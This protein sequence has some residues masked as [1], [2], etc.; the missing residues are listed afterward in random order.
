[1]NVKEMPAGCEMDALITEKV[2]G[3]VPCDAWSTLRHFPPMFI[4]GACEH[5]TCYP[6]GYPCKYSSNM[7][8]AWQ[9]IEKLIELG[10]E[11]SVCHLSDKWVCV[12]EGSS[13]GWE[14]D[15]PFD[16]AAYSE[17]APLAICRAALLEIG[18]EEIEA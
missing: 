3:A 7:G 9:V 4:R 2:M 16:E 15:L 13:A 1:M 17:T 6:R 12:R 8:A 11:P 14:V 18:I 5:E 10:C